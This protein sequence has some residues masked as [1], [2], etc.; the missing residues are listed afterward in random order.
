MLI[1]LMVIDQPVTVYPKSK[2]DEKVK[3]TQK[4]LDAVTAEW[5]KN[6]ADDDLVGR[7]VSLN[8]LFGKEWREKNKQDNNE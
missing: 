7:K 1:D 6:H 5:K 3:H 8:E 4:E 2:K